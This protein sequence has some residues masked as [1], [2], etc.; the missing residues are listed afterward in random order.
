ME[1][2][3]SVDDVKNFLFEKYNVKSLKSLASY[4]GISAP[5]ASRYFGNA[6]NQYNIPAAD[7]LEKVAFHVASTYKEENKAIWENIYKLLCGKDDIWKERLAE[8]IKKKEN[9]KQVDSIKSARDE[10]NTTTTLSIEEKISNEEVAS[11][12]LLIIAEEIIEKIEYKII[13]KAVNE[14]E[15]YFRVER[16]VE[17]MEIFTGGCIEHIKV[18]ELTEDNYIETKHRVMNLNEEDGFILLYCNSL[19]VL[20][21]AWKDNSFKVHNNLLLYCAEK[22]QKLYV[23]S[24]RKGQRHFL[25]NLFGE[26]NLIFP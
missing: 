9:D 17:I 13:E 21:E 18:I 2:L 6:K 3:S 10:N 20:D 4:L 8:T 26:D 19:F 24:K 7:I 5:T 22:K 1:E 12:Q 14:D 25:I 16:K 15:A 23:K 11:N